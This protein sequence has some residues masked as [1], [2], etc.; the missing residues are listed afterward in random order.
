MSLFTLGD[1]SSGIEIY[2]I[3]QPSEGCVNLHI[4]IDYPLQGDVQET[5]RK[6]LHP[7]LTIKGDACKMTF[8]LHRDMEALAHASICHNFCFPAPAYEIVEFAEDIEKHI[9]RLDHVI[10]GVY[11]IIVR[12]QKVQK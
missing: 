3:D 12:I 8:F 7:C 5:I 6:L 9:F 10:R 2:H 1:L 4:D 11:H